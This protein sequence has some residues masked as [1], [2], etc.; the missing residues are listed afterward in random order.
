MLYTLDRNH[1][2]DCT[3]YGGCK[4]CTVVLSLNVTC[5]ADN[6]TMMVTSNHLEVVPQ[7]D[8]PEE[9]AGEELTKRHDNFGQPV[10]KGTVPARVVSFG[11]L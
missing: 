4:Y 9:T 6:T 3:C 1:G 5:T 2:Q 11:R 8:N 10:G 7:M